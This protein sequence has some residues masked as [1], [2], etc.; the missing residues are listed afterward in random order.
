MW[1]LKKNL[2]QKHCTKTYASFLIRTS[3]YINGR[4]SPFFACSMLFVGRFFH[5]AVARRRQNGHLLM[6][7]DSFALSPDLGAAG[8]AGQAS[9]GQAIL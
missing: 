5:A 8:R 9:T 3:C 7:D 6:D 4:F 1:F 2:P